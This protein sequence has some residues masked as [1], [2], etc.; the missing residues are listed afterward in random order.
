MLRRAIA[1]VLCAAVSL[2]FLACKKEAPAPSGAAPTKGETS[3]S[4]KREPFGKLADGTPIDIYT[5]ANKNGLEARVMTYGAILV[6]VRLP[7]R[8]G[9]LEDVVLGFDDLAGY[10]G[11]HP[12][13]GAII[14][15]YGNRIAN[16]KFSLGG[17]TY[18]LA[19]NNNANSL[20]GGVRGFDKV[21]ME[22]RA[23]PRVRCRR[24]PSDLSQ[25][26]R[27]GGLSRQPLGRRGLHADGVRRAQDRLRG[28]DRQSHAY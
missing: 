4:V 12:Y 14:G 28:R 15:R 11:G 8:N 17:A 23:R 6:S 16:G 21:V 25:Q 7:D 2:A 18:T 10:L 22:G 26:G 27:G 3:M 20:H 19:R 24:R 5:L 9:R 1:A 13:F